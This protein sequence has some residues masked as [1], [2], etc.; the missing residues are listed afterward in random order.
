[1]DNSKLERVRKLLAKAEGAA[2]EGERDAY[3]EKA[4]KLIA[5]YGI[6]AALLAAAEKR[7][8]RVADRLIKMDKPYAAEKAHLLHAI[9]KPMGVK[10][11][12]LGSGAN[13]QVHVF[14]VQS[15]LDRVEVLFTSLLVQAARGA[16]KAMPANPWSYSNP[17]GEDVASY[18]RSWFRGFADVLYVRIEEIERRARGESEA[19]GTGVELVLFDRSKLVAQA[20][21]EAYPRLTTLRMGKPKRHAYANGADAG[22]NAD[23]GQKRMAQSRTAIGS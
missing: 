16:A 5:E 10:T 21:S 2:T 20:V 19:S 13:V 8:E 3:N 17:Y 1:M 15:D 23:I 9:A 7:D 11:V 14:G 4:S 12:R 6:D 22:R 18:R